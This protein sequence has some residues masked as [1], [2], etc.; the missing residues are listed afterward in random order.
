[1]YF[2]KLSRTPRSIQ[3][4][5]TL[6]ELEMLCICGGVTTHLPELPHTR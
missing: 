3:I 2:I 4:S 5:A 6:V 1:M